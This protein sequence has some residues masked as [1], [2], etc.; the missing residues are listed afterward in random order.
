[1][2]RILFMVDVPNPEHSA[3]LAE[4]LRRIL[5]EIEKR[6]A[7]TGRILTFPETSGHHDAIMVLVEGYE[8]YVAVTA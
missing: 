4:T 2:T 5:A 3:G 8:R 7:G 1:M 6:D